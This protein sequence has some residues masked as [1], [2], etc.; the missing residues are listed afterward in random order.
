MAVAAMLEDEHDVTT[1]EHGQE[2]LQLLSTSSFD[3]VLCDL[4]MPT[5]SASEFFAELGRVAPHQMSNVYF[6]TG[7]IFTETARAFLDSAKRPL[8]NKPFTL[9][10]LRSLVAQRMQA[11]P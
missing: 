5:M 10:A 7:G 2:A 9:S 11:R 8:L 4:M 3:V 6:M 1:A